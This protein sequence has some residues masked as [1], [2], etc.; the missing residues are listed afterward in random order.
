MGRPRKTLSD[1]L[2]DPSEKHVT[3]ATYQKAPAEAFLRYAVSVK[4]A[5]RFA[6]THLPK[7]AQGTPTKRTQE[8][9]QQL[10]LSMLPALMGHFETYERYL[11]AGL[12]ERSV[13]L[14]HFSI[15]TFFAKLTNR[16]SD[17]IELQRLAAY[18][19][20][21]VSSVGSLL[22][23][24]LAGWQSPARVNRYFSA[25]QLNNALFSGEEAQEL[26]ILWQFRHSIVHSGGT[27][28]LADAQK[29][30]SLTSLRERQLAFE[31]PFIPEVVRRFHFIVCRATTA[32]EKA[33][34]DELA[35][36]EQAA[37]DFQRFLTVKSPVAVWLCHDAKRNRFS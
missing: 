15:E 20:T 7:T 8:S 30:P 2:T 11:F 26:E 13:H 29:V 33:V 31:S 4:N 16:K 19:E 35:D 6:E 24:S 10:S 17:G 9:L 27:L 1:Y 3:H 32:L 34:M 28:T 12:F 21:G 22:A 25:F 14:P 36:S 18:R 23:D 37:T 5:F